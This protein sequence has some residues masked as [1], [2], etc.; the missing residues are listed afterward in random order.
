M[1]FRGRKLSKHAK[2]A[3][4]SCTA[5]DRKAGQTPHDK[6]AISSGQ[7]FWKTDAEP[8]LSVI[9]G[10]HLNMIFVLFELFSETNMTVPKTMIYHLTELLFLCQQLRL[11]IVKEKNKIY[12]KGAQSLLATEVV[13]Q[14]TTPFRLVLPSAHFEL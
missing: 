9:S 4:R 11:D 3:A 13:S 10:N 6:N 5:T 7:G 8:N 2:I 12:F 1:N 14:P